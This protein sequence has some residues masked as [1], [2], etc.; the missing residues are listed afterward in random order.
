MLKARRFRPGATIRLLDRD[1]SPGD[2]RLRLLERR[3]SDGAWLVAVLA[4]EP[5]L[6]ILDR[7]GLTPLP[8]YIRAAR[9]RR[10][11]PSDDASDRETYQTVYAGEAGSVA[12]PTAGLHVTPDLLRTLDERGI[13]RGEVV[14]HVGM[15]TF[16]PV[17]VENLDDHP[18]HAEW[19]SM[20][21]P[22]TREIRDR[23]EGKRQG[24]VIALGT[25]SVRTI[26]TYARV[27]A[28]EPHPGSIQTRLLIAPGHAPLWTQG[29]LTNFHLPRSTL[30]ALVAAMLDDPPGTGARRV[31][32][33]YAEAID[34]HYRFYSFGDAMLILP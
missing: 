8:P 15:G 1:G 27:S 11:E 2:I 32:E 3:G 23:A 31:R 29:L 26:E 5:T 17:E 33:L 28:S 20:P 9:K 16:K 34:M 13:R 14:L 10:G 19:C 6:A 25:T 30:L 12:A 21:E 24:R 7:V 18:M 4:D 22:I